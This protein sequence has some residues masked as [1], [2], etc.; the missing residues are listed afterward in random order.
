MNGKNIEIALKVE[1]GTF[2]ETYEET[3][4]LSSTHWKQKL[5]DK[6]SIVIF[7]QSQGE[8]VG[9]M[10]LVTGEKDELEETAV[11]HELYVNEAYRGRGVGKNLLNFLISEVKKDRRVKFLKLWVKDVQLPA[12]RLYE[13]AGFKFTERAGEHTAIME[14]ELF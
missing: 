4:K 14:K 9:L 10:S 6:N 2:H 11:I 7:A 1:P 13:S 3:E 8:V 12:R 5:A